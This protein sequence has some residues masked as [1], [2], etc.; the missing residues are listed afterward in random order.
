[1]GLGCEWRHARKRWT[2]NLVILKKDVS[3]DPT[4][5]RA[6]LAGGY[7]MRSA[8]IGSDNAIS[9]VKIV[10]LSPRVKKLKVKN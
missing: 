8:F 4:R 6:S 10:S 1:M 2:E 7:G 3:W 5:G 9:I